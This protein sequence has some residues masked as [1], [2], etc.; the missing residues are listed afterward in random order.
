MIAVTDK[1]QPRVIT[2]D[3]WPQLV[4]L[5]A[6]GDKTIS[7]FIFF[8]ADQYKDKIPEELDSTVLHQVNSLLS[9]RIIELRDEKTNLPDDIL[10]PR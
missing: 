9:E 4:F 10:R 7:E 1:H 2:M 5:E 6:T 3:D 8:L